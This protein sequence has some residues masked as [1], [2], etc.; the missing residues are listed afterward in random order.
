MTPTEYE[1]FVQRVIQE[2]LSDPKNVVHHQKVYVGRVSQRKI[3]IDVSFEH[4]IIGAKILF[5]VE[6]KKY[7]N[8]VTV[9]DIEEFHSKCDDIGAHKGLVV[10]TVGFQK[11]CYK[12]AAGRGIALALLTSDPYPGEMMIVQKSQ[13]GHYGSKESFLNGVYFGLDEP[14]LPTRFKSYDDFMYNFILDLYQSDWWKDNW[15]RLMKEQN[16]S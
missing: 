2:L 12:V 1:I 6:C 5:L 3:K 10:T 15:I 13:S 8:M 7:S 11:G 14:P 16:N 9:D 4:E